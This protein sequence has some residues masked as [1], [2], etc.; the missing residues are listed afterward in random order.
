MILILTHADDPA[1]LDGERFLRGRG[2]DVVRFEPSRFP[3]STA[4]TLSWRADA[5]ARQHL[6]IDGRRID[7]GDVRAV[8]HRRARARRPEEIRDPRMRSFA[9]RESDAVLMQLWRELAAPFL[10]APL[11]VIRA[12]QDKLPQL[13]LAISLGFAI[14]PTLVTSEPAELLAFHREHDGRIITKLIS[15]ASLDDSGLT[16]EFQRF[17]EPVTWTDLGACDSV[18]LCPVLAQAYVPKRVE[19]RVTVVGERVFP[20]EIDSQAA[21]HSRHD[22]RKYDHGRAP[23]RV[24]D[25]P[26]DVAARC[27]AI[28]RA[29]GLRYGAIDLIVTPDG[30]YVFLEINPAGEFHWVEQRT[31]LP[32]TAA[33]ADLL[34]AM[35]GSHAASESR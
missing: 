26:A 10:P 13:T 24:H 5:R 15:H 19:L 28:T 8:W 2:A 29:L 25:L 7:L 3:G 33:I 22:W 18:R 27:V 21:Q 1:A 9:N 31:G 4:L 6:T 12:A 32:I 14:P 11:P 34:I 30:R 16:H 35:A 17:T 20:A 23:Y